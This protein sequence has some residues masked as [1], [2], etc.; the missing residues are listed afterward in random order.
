MKL[1]YLNSGGGKD[2]AGFLTTRHLNV[3]NRLTEVK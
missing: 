2:S 3:E 1:E